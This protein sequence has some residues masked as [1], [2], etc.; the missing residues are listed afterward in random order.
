[1]STL[2]FVLGFALALLLAAYVA[3]LRARRFRAASQAREAAVLAAVL[4]RNGSGQEGETI[5]AGVQTN[6]PAHAGIEVA[7]VVDLDALLQGLSSNQAERTRERLEEPTA[8]NIGSINTSPTAPVRTP[9]LPAGPPPVPAALQRLSSAGAAAAPDRPHNAAS[10]SPAGRSARFGGELPLRE[11]ALTWF[12]ARGYR[13][14]P[15]SP[16]V[17]P[18]QR[19]LRHKH[20]PARAYAVVVEVQQVTPERVQELRH[21]AREIGLMRL[22]IVAAAGAA[23]RAA[24]GAKGVRLIDR[25]ALDHELSQLDV[26]VAAKIIAVA[27]RRAAVAKG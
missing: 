12:E 27:G 19:V 4:G 2:V 11:L 22:L 6:L 14:A 10:A 24:K 15:A 25:Q 7:E 18:I 16:A 23:P 21:R 3:V 9:L 17:H 26:A 1:M 13:C 5:F 8:I 20:N